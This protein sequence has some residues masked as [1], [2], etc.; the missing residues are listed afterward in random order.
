LKFIVRDMGADCS[1]RAD[2]VLPSDIPPGTTVQDLV[3]EVI[4]ALHARLVGD[5]APDDALS[6]A[7]RIEGCGSWTA[8]IRGRQML[9]EVGEETRPT[10]WMY[11]T[12][13]SALRFLEDALGPKRFLPKITN[14]LGVLTMSDPQVIKRVAMANGRIELA[15]R[16]DD[17]ARLAVVFGFGSAA[18][19]P[20]DPERPE[21]IAEATMTTLERSLGGELGPQEAISSGQVTV[22]GSR[23]LAMQLALAVAPFWA[24]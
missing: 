11:T 8:R 21:T 15:V 6:V 13:R 2:P 14:G 17:G 12:E 22:R 4:P 1:L 7:V 24:K 16:D 5:G 19:R 3:T 23:L 18:R 20:I 9:V 10:L